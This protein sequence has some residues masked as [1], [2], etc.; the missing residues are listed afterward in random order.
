MY[1]PLDRQLVEPYSNWDVDQIRRMF[2]HAELTPAD[3]V[4][5]GEFGSWTITYFTGAYGLGRFGRVA[6]PFKYV[7]GWGAFQNTDPSADNYFSVECSNPDANIELLIEHPQSSVFPLHHAAT[8]VVGGLSLGEGEWIRFN[9][10]DTSQGSSGWRVQHFSEDAHPWSVWVDA[11]MSRHYVQV[12]GVPPLRIV[13]GSADRLTLTM[14]SN[15][16]P[17]EPAWLCARVVDRFNNTATSFRGSMRMEQHPDVAGLP[18]FVEFGEAEQG[19]AR[20][21]GIS[22]R[23]PGIVRL[24]A[25]LPGTAIAATSNPVQCADDFERRLYFG[26]LQS[27]SNETAGTNTAESLF[28]FARNVSCIDFLAH[29]AND[30]EL[31]QEDYE[32]IRGLARDYNEPGRF[33]TIQAYEWSGLTPGGGDHCVLYLRDDQPIYRSGH[34]KVFDGSDTEMDRYPVS[35]LLETF[36][37]RKDVFVTPH[38]GGRMATLDDFDP[39]LMPYLEICSTHGRFEWYGREAIERGLTIGFVGSTDDHT[40]RPGAGYSAFADA[41]RGGLAAV[42]SSNLTRQ[43]LW[44]GIRRRHVYATT[45]DRIILDVKVNGASMGEEARLSE[46]P[47]IDV[48]IHA[49]GPIRSLEVLRDLDVIYAHGLTRGEAFAADRLRFEWSDPDARAKGPIQWDGDLEISHGRIVS[50]SR[51]AYH[52]PVEPITEVSE[53]RVSWISTTDLGSVTF[54]GRGR[55][56]QDGLLI[57]LE[58][59]DQAILTFRTRPVSF[60]QSVSALLTEAHH[61][62]GD[63]LQG[64]LT[65]GPVPEQPGPLDVEFT[66]RDDDAPAGRHAY[67]VR[68]IQEDNEIAWSSPTWVDLDI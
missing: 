16:T 48:E 11:F 64:G 42:Y 38:V 62:S 41:R 54:T 33:V 53:R 51:Y 63:G 58:E 66:F 52:S 49:T 60:Q 15:T 12:P 1:R 3:P 35:A 34:F 47:A 28:Q 6:L 22:V 27:Q 31:Q 67:W 59:A 8:A 20:I 5:V 25:E 19:V 13:A 24:K 57:S 40:G 43:S 29:T 45:G 30:W 10:G 39:T 4:T 46:T 18:K 17:N 56:D 9:L 36:R 61:Y 68:A 50:A 2:G 14:P 65:A 37:G 32:K 23:N 26:D 55:G 44:D 7:S 21:E